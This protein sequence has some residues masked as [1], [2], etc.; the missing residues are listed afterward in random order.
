MYACTRL[1]ETLTTGPINEMTC[2]VTLMMNAIN[3]YA[4]ARRLAIASE[5]SAAVLLILI[6]R[7]YRERIIRLRTRASSS[8][9]LAPARQRL[10]LIIALLLRIPICVRDAILMIELC[11][12]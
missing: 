2:I 11:V 12:E 7:I 8:A 9:H 4:S 6:R 3:L 10:G 5:R 1:S